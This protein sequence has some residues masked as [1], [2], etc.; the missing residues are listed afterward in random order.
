MLVKQLNSKLSDRPA[1]E[2]ETQVSVKRVLL[3][4]FHFSVPAA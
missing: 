2:R 1:T 3:S 4:L